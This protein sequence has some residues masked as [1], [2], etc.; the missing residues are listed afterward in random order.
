MQHYRVL[1]GWLLVA[2]FTYVHGY[3]LPS[4]SPAPQSELVRRA[5]GPNAAAKAAGLKWF[6]SCYDG[7]VAGDAALMKYYN[8]PNFIGQLTP[9]NSMKPSSIDQGGGKYNFGAGDAVVAQAKKTGATVRCHFLAGPDQNGASLWSLN[10]R[11]ATLAYVD[12]YISAVMQHFGSACYSWDVVNEAL[13]EQGGIRTNVPWTGK[14]GQDFVEQIFAIATKH[15]PAGVKL[16]YNDYNLE[17]SPAKLQGALGL[18]SKIKAAGGRIDCIGFESHISTSYHPTLQSYVGSLSKVCSAGIEAPVT[19]LDVANA[20]G[21]GEEAQ[22]EAYSIA[23]KACVQAK[24]C[25]GVT[26][27]GLSDKVDICEQSDGSHSGRIVQP[28]TDACSSLSHP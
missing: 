3:A 1:V 2:L 10:G 28:S 15:A 21:G 12:K 14:I 9:E 25:P 16:C 19:E 7:K 18:V 8:D 26:V 22:A 24:C 27:W 4:S 17:S 6:G 23:V 11:A 20:G 13:T 5:N